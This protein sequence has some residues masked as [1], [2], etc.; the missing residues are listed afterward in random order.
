MDEG[1]FIFIEECGDWR[2]RTLMQAITHNPEETAQMAADVATEVIKRMP[3]AS[4]A[5][6]LGLTGELGSG[7]TTFVQAFARALGVQTRPKSPTFTLMHEYPIPESSL[8]LWH[9][10]CYRLEGRKDLEALDLA[11]VLADPTNIVL[12]E[13]PERA[14]DILPRDRVLI[15]FGHAGEDKRSVSV[16][17]P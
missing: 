6:V 1:L 11:S 17:W 9:L 5:M 10:D 8:S 3:S 16:K 15:R 7:K 14:G 4:A 2:Y 12:I 13:W